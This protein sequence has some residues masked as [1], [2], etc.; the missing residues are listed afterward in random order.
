[1]SRFRF[2]EKGLCCD[3]Y[4]N[5]KRNIDKCALFLYGFPATIG[6]NNLTELL[7]DM[8]YTVL[9]PHYYGTYDSTG[10]FS[11]QSAF[12]TVR[13]IVEIASGSLVR[14]LKSDTMYKLPDTISI[15]IGYSFGAY[16]LRHTVQYL[17]D[18]EEVFLFSPVMSNSP[19]NKLCWVNE[20][21]QEHL[22]YVMRT[23]PF[24]YRIKDKEIWMKSYVNDVYVEKEL[25]TNNINNVLWFYGKN[26]DAMIEQKIKEKYLFATRECI[27]S[28]ANVAIHCVD[29]GD[30]GINTLIN[31]ETIGILNSVF[32]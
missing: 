17:K 16:V 20:N 3:V 26:D 15:C 18:L 6:S 5:K 9:H 29:D 31:D 12:E 14:N 2:I 32:E 4:Y 22:N 28:K 11:P 30:H 13:A 10:D 27:S 23:R 24:T 1:M 8:G 21:G 19:T 25:V 7:V